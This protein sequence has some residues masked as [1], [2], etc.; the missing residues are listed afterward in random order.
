[1]LGGGMRCALL[2]IL[3]SSLAWAEDTETRVHARSLFKEGESAFQAGR[4][5]DA[6]AKYQEAYS[7]VPLPLLLFD[8]GQAHRLKGEPEKAV[9]YYRKYLDVEPGG[10]AAGEAR[11]HVAALEPEV[12]ARRAADEKNAAEAQQAELAR[13]TAEQAAH[14]QSVHVSE[15][16]AKPAARTRPKWIWGVVGGGVAVV[17]GVALGVGLGVGLSKT[18]YPAA[19]S[20][21]S[22]GIH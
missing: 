19:S 6:I 13:Q 8:L 17:V 4:Y 3:A 15:V 16:Q 2:V 20:S 5:D 9:G 22:T 21:V 14:A 11:E 7:L 1:M 18:E 10:K 12:R